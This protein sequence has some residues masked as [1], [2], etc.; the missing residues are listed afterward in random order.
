MYPEAVKLADAGWLEPPYV[1]ANGDRSWF[2][3]PQAEAALD[4]NA[5]PQRSGGPELMGHPA[6]EPPAT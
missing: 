3:T 6:A 4:P 5:P 1:D 2:W